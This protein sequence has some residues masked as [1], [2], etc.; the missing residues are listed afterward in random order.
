PRR[1]ARPRGVE[2]AAGAHRRAGL[3]DSDATSKRAGPAGSPAAHRRAQAHGGTA[4]RRGRPRPGRGGARGGRRRRRWGAGPPGRPSG[5]A[6]FVLATGGV[7]SGGLELELDGTV[8]ETVLDLPV[9]GVPTGDRFAAGSLDP[10]PL[11]RAGLAVDEK[12][13]PVDADGRTVYENVHA[14]GAMLAGAEP[15]REKSGDGIS[16]AS[17]IRAAEA[18]QERLS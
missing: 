2:R 7:A 10:Q 12:L 1:R 8:R 6:A 16:L 4:D 5:A 14:V 3:R 18:I 17:G 13:R 9:A 11:G 15:W